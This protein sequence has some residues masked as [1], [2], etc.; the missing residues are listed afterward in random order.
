MS[1]DENIIDSNMMELDAYI[2]SSR[3]IGITR[4][5]C[6]FVHN[7]PEGFSLWI[8]QHGK[9]I[10]LGVN[11]QEYSE[12]VMDHEIHQWINWMQY[13][14]YKCIGEHIFDTVADNGMYK[15]G[16]PAQQGF[17][18]LSRDE[19]ESLSDE[20]KGKRVVKNQITTALK[21][22]GLDAVDMEDL[23]IDMTKLQEF[24]ELG[25]DE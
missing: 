12:V 14:F 13:V 1:E 17:A 24:I 23:G 5:A 20:E 3:M 2:E 10:G 9:K 8:G 18:F 19:Y 11:G 16:M 15:T 21:R 6:E 25:D 7:D 22:M 4:M